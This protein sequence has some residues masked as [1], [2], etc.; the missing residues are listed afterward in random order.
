MFANGCVAHGLNSYLKDIC[1]SSSDLN[2]L[3]KDSAFLTKQLHYHTRLNEEFESIRKRF[4]K[5]CR[6]QIA[7]PTRFSSEFIAAESVS[8]NKSTMY[9]L[10]TE[11]EELVNDSLG[12]KAPKFKEIIESTQ[13][14]AELRYVVKDLF[15]KPAEAIK[16]VEGHN[17]HIGIV[18]ELCLDLK[19]H[20]QGLPL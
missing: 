12:Q 6:S 10:L 15:S 14:W 19:E 7:V 3:L 17:I 8:S 1:K 18:Y 13:F 11:N 20:I 4:G 5:G 16:L 9:H 2:D